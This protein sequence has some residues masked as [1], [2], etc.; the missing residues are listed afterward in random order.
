MLHLPSLRERRAFFDTAAYL[1][2][3]DSRD[4]HHS[5]AVHILNTIT[6]A[7]YRHFTTNT[8]LIEAHALIMSRLGVGVASRFLQQ[9][10]AGN[11]AIVRS[12][13]SDEENAKQILYQFSDKDFS[14]TDAISFVVMRRLGVTQA[15]TFDHHF[16]QY[17]FIILTSG[18]R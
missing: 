18:E 2:L 14:F 16:A 12:R 7:R 15:F 1:A 9:L 10:A 13:A 5:E 6:A 3:L 11:T 17:G 4:G 8:V